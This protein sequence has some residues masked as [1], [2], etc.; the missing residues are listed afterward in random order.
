MGRTIIF[1]VISLLL[2]IPFAYADVPRLISV[3]GRLTDNFNTLITAPTDFVFKIY[4]GLGTELWS[5]DHTQANGNPVT[6]DSSGVF[7]VLLGSSNPLNIGF[8]EPY[9]LEVQIEGET[10]TPRQQIGSAGYAIRSDTPWSSPATEYL[11]TNYKYVGIGNLLDMQPFWGKLQIYVPDSENQQISMYIE[12]TENDDI[13]NYGVYSKSINNGPFNANSQG[14]YGSAVGTS[15]GMHIGVHG[16][17]SATGGTNYGIYGDAQDAPVNWAGYFKGGNVYVENR[18]GIGTTNPARKLH[19]N[20]TDGMRLNPSALPGT[21]AAGD[22]AIDSGD[23]NRLKWHNGTAW[24]TMGGSEGGYCYTY[25]ST[26]FPCICPGGETNKKDLGAWGYCDCGSGSGIF[27]KHPGLACTA[28]WPH[29]S[30]P[31]GGANRGSACVCCGN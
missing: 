13:G 3:Q 12:H 28:V 19:I 18:L 24:Q 14:V 1:F 17:A 7:S 22:I 4:D 26:S 15:P 2:A 23:S 16:V 25:Y 8:D 11:N 30:N 21:P 9:W 5:E 27:F 20:G 31:C 29:G 6:P 10:L